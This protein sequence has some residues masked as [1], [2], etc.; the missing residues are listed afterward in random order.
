MVAVL[1]VLSGTASTDS[2]VRP[3]MLTQIRV[4]LKHSAPQKAPRMRA[5]TTRPTVGAS[6][7]VLVETRAAVSL[8]PAGSCREKSQA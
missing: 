3:A 1:R 8:L 6:V 7:S 5:A 4:T 2:D